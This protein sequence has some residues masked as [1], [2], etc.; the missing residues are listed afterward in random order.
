MGGIE[1]T[2][3]VASFDGLISAGQDIEIFEIGE[4]DRKPRALYQNQPVY[5]YTLKQRRIEG[6]VI[7]E[8]IITD[9]GRVA[10]PRVSQ[11]SHQ[12]FRQPTIDS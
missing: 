7:R 4:L 3:L 1:G 8:W 10:Q 11:S 6:W 5:P 2:H 9:N 12:E